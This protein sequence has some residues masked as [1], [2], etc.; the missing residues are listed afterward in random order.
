MVFTVILFFSVSY[1]CKFSPF[2]QMENIMRCCVQYRR[3]RVWRSGICSPAN[4][5][6]AWRNEVLDAGCG[7]RSR[8]VL[9]LCRAFR[10]RLV[11]HFVRCVGSDYQQ[12]DLVQSW[13]CQLVRYEEYSHDDQ[14]SVIRQLT[15]T[16]VKHRTHTRA[17]TPQ[18]IL[19]SVPCI[20]LHWTG[21]VRYW[22]Y[23]WYA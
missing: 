12:S 14:A 5:G 18:V 20:V 2:L 15:T 22:W 1:F 16:E 11:D 19:Y 17:N 13:W 4:R 7:S 6:S 9:Q 23:S 21:R 3:C 8:C 10:R